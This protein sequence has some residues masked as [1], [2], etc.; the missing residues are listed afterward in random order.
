MAHLILWWKGWKG[1][2]PILSNK[3]L[4]SEVLWQLGNG[5][6]ASSLLV[7]DSM[8]SMF[9]CVQFDGNDVD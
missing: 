9:V 2:L 8:A 1:C 5:F 4:R 6:T 3:I 7:S